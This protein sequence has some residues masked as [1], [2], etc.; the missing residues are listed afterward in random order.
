MIVLKPK[1]A[2]LYEHTFTFYP[3]DDDINS[4]TLKS[5]D[6]LISRGDPKDYRD[7]M[8]PFEYIRKSINVES[9]LSEVSNNGIVVKNKET[10]EKLHISIQRAKHKKEEIEFDPEDYTATHVY[11][12]EKILK[13][14]FGR[15]FSKKEVYLTSTTYK[16]EN[17][18]SIFRGGSVSVQN[19]K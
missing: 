4:F 13:L 10:G 8:L 11:L 6:E 3:E 12:Y 2:N 16:R 15:P 17:P 19:T 14:L 5:K 18:Q 9:V 7:C 1:N